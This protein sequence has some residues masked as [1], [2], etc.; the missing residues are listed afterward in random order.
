MND[1][2]ELINEIID[3]DQTM[4]NTEDTSTADAQNACYLFSHYLKWRFDELKSSI[5]LDNLPQNSILSASDI[6]TLDMLIAAPY[7]PWNQWITNVCEYCHQ[8]FSQQAVSA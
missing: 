6:E 8:L 4:A 1:I 7:S 3:F 5:N 2:N